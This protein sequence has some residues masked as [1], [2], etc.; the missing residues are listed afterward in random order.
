MCDVV[1]AGGLS[2]LIA[3]LATTLVGGSAGSGVLTGAGLAGAAAS[4]ASILRSDGGSP[5][6][7]VVNPPAK[8]ET[9]Q[10]GM[11][12]LKRRR[13]K[14]GRSD[15]IVAGALEPMD[16]GKRTLLG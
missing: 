13:R 4:G 5:K 12:M 2:A 1:L 8:P 9:G 14:S 16:T 7:P 3:S 10:D 11:D 6:V 15:T